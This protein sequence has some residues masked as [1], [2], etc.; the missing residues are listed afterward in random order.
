MLH[1]MLGFVIHADRQR[2][3]EV[4]LRHRRLLDPLRRPVVETVQGP[5]TQRHARQE[6]AGVAS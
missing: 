3:I 2:E 4:N 5:L 1:L 6:R